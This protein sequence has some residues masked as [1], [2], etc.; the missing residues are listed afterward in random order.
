VKLGN[1]FRKQ[2]D[3]VLRGGKNGRAK[4]RTSRAVKE[5]F[6]NI[7]EEIHAMDEQTVYEKAC[8]PQFVDL[9]C[10]SE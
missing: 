3:Y 4:S 6:N 8:D 7:F 10:F 2:L 9:R 5:K 1:Y